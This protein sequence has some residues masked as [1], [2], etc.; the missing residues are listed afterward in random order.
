MD[1]LRTTNQVTDLFVLSLELL[2]LGRQS[3]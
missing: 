1:S 3:G 2:L